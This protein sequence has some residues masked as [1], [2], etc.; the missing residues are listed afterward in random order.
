M[1]GF[2]AFVQILTIWLVPESPRW[3]IYHNRPEEAYEILK[4]YHGNGQDTEFVQASYAEIRETIEL[5]RSI[6][7]AK[8]VN[9]ISTPGNRRRTLLCFLQGMFSQ[10]SGTGLVSYYLVPVLEGKS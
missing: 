10:F 3:L 9:L 1:Q 7:N 8:W 5:E 6:G 2:P 4:K